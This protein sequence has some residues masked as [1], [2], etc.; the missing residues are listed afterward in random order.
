MSDLLPTLEVR[1]KDGAALLDE[2]LPGWAAMIDLRRLNLASCKQC[3]LGQSARALGAD[4]DVFGSGMFALWPDAD[5][6]AGMD[7]ATSHGFYSSRF[8]EYDELDRLWAEQVRIRA[9]TP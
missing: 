4:V 7:M 8:G 6:A 3:V 2:R 9:E 5:L 1:V